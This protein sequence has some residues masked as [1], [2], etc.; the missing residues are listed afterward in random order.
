MG[1]PHRSRG[2]KARRRRNPAFRL[3]GAI[4]AEANATGAADIAAGG[5]AAAQELGRI[6]E[7]SAGISKDTERIKSITNTARYRIPDV[8][9]HR[10]AVMDEVKNVR[11]HSYTNQLR[12]FVAYAHQKGYTFE[13]W[14]RPTTELSGPLVE[15]ISKGWIKLRY[16]P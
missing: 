16:L 11:R 3:R 13:L 6:G 7:A 15:A 1:G 14:V 9:D 12:D 8:L 4:S 10:A 5:T 2:L